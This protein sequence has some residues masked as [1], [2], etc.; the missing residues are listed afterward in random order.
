MIVGDPRVFAI[1]SK[2]TKAYERLSFRAL[3]FFVIH[4]SGR[5]YGV[6]S[7]EATMLACSFDQVEN[8]T[9]RCGTHTTPFAAE[10]SGG[11]I[12]DAFLAAV[13]G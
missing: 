5:R 13:Y 8:R 11:E 1:E 12:A 4:V 9:A 10:I 6:H 3:G 2:I 7:P